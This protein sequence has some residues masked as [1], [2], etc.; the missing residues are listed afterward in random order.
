MIELVFY[1]EAPRILLAIRRISE[2]RSAFGV[3]VKLVLN[4]SIL[5]AKD[6]VEVL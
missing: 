2:K 6:D 3:A 4:I 1:E 5:T